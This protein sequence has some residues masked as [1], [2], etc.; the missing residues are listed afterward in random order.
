MQSLPAAD[1]LHGARASAVRTGQLQPE[2]DALV[3]VSQRVVRGESG[4][5]LRF[6]F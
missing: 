1:D 6:F 3:D 2:P 5:S 4:M